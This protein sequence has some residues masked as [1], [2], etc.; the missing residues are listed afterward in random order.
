M[1]KSSRP[2]IAGQLELPLSGDDD[3]HP[4]S[5]PPWSAK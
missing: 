2:Q 4:D 1:S 3:E 5:I